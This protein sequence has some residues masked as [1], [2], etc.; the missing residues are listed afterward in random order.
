MPRS[1]TKRFISMVS[2]DDAAGLLADLPAGS[3]PRDFHILGDLLPLRC[4]MYG[5]IDCLLSLARVRPELAVEVLNLEDGNGERAIDWAAG[6]ATPSQARELIAL[7][8]LAASNPN[9]SG[10]HPLA[11]ALSSNRF[12]AAALWLDACPGS[13]KATDGYGRTMLHLACE[14]GAGSDSAEIKSWIPPSR[15]LVQALIGA[16]ANPCVLDSG[17]FNAL[18]RAAA[19][20]AQEAFEELL[21]NIPADEM[22]QSLS[23]G[24]APFGP[25][26]QAAFHN[27]PAM[28]ALLAAKG[29]DMAETT[30]KGFGMFHVAIRQGAFAAA[31]ALHDAN[32]PAEPEGSTTSCPVSALAAEEN[33]KW[34]SWLAER[35]FD[36][37]ERDDHW[38][39]WA[40]LAWEKQSAAEAAA[41]WDA[42]GSATPA[43]AG[44]SLF[45]PLERAARS[46]LEPAEK[47]KLLLERGLMPARMNVDAAM[48]AGA[49]TPAE[50]LSAARPASI[51]AHSFGA[52]RFLDLGPMWDTAAE[53]KLYWKPDSSNHDDRFLGDL[54][55]DEAPVRLNAP[56]INKFYKRPSLL[57]FCSANNSAES[58]SFLFEWDKQRGWFSDADHLCAWRAALASDAKL[59]VLRLCKASLDARSIEAWGAEETSTALQS[60]GPAKRKELGA[61]DLSAGLAIEKL[62]KSSGFFDAMLLNPRVFDSTRQYFKDSRSSID[63]SSRPWNAAAYSAH[64][65]ALKSVFSSEGPYPAYAAL[66][67]ALAAAAAEKG[68]L[69]VWIAKNLGSKAKQAEPNSPWGRSPD[70]AFELWDQ[71]LRFELRQARAIKAALPKNEAERC[72]YDEFSDPDK[73]ADFLPEGSCASGLLSMLLINDQEASAQKLLEMGLGCPTDFTRIAA[74][75]GKQAKFATSIGEGSEKLTSLR[76]F[77]EA[78]C[79]RSDYQAILNRTSGTPILSLLPDPALFDAFE[80]AGADPG[81]GPSNAYVQLCTRYASRLSPA[82]AERL[83]RAA[84]R[85]EPGM[86][87]L[88]ATALAGMKPHAT[89]SELELGASAASRRRIERAALGVDK[90]GWFSSF[91]QGSCPVAK[92]IE[93]QNIDIALDLARCAPEGYAERAGASWPALWV[94]ARVPA[95]GKALRVIANGY[96]TDITP[97]AQAAL[98]T[99]AHEAR[100]LADLG[101]PLGKHPDYEADMCAQSLANTHRSRALTLNWLIDQGLDP[102]GTALA[103]N[104]EYSMERRLGRALDQ[105]GYEEPPSLRLPLLCFALGEGLAEEEAALCLR[106]EKA[107]YLG[108]IAKAD[109]LPSITYAAFLD[110]KAASALEAAILQDSLE[111]QEPSANKPSRL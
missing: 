30:A 26:H 35:G 70:L 89:R 14:S 85:I 24:E 68:S 61:P 86:P 58:L 7:S 34:L 17:K 75:I 95:I 73:Q 38:A 10:R 91:E 4:A 104:L 93:S 106:W 79:K 52:Y 66:Y 74:A 45:G 100:S 76:S 57:A 82:F 20:G 39:H 69:A 1:L 71:Q 36:M 21:K 19:S 53:D 97:K 103:E 40:E 22:Q 87:L 28:I 27:R 13:A 49:A 65:G 33:S 16:G 60:L 105:A 109:G 59:S 83:A 80:E 78:L 42:L 18:S 72:G 94:K 12:E 62:I 108:V 41:S 96:P 54:D 92:A 63:N 46:S 107:G 8:P 77:C 47:I 102:R 25:G 90:L 50:I 99:M 56:P 43:R 88:V 31:Q 101:Q 29:L 67:C 5:A 9:R 3:D 15:T 55:F 2:K 111:E 110:G 81:L 37:N 44:F 32:A 11:S 6:W 98:D 48:A 23:R 64:D 84:R 51:H